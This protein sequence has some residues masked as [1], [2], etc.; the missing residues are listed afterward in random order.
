MKTYPS[1]DIGWI[2]LKQSI[3]LC[4]PTEIH[5]LTIQ[6]ILFW[7]ILRQEYKGLH[8]VNQ[9]N[10]MLGKMYISKGF[11]FNPMRL[12]LPMFHKNKKIKV[13]KNSLI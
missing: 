6:Q 4:S 2:R 10:V 5:K 12:H 1:C 7:L 9:A 8:P 11:N 3:L 13:T